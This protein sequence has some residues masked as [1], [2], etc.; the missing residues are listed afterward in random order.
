VGLFSR[1]FGYFIREAPPTPIG[2]LSAFE[3]WMDGTGTVR[4]SSIAQA[5]RIATVHACIKVLSEDIASLPCKLY[6]ATDDGREVAAGH[7]LNEFVS[8]APGARLT[9]FEL[10]EG[11]VASMLFTGKSARQI[12]RDGTGKIIDLAELD[13]TRM[14]PLDDAGSR[15]LYDLGSGDS[16]TIARN[17]LWLCDYWLGLSPLALAAHQL[18]HALGQDEHARAYFANNAVLG[19]VLEYPGKL[20]AEDREKLLREWNAAHQGSARAWRTGLLSGGL[21]FTPYT[22]SNRDAQFLEARRFTSEQIAAVYRV[23]LAKINDLTHATYNNV[24]QQSISYY[25]DTLRPNLDRIEQSM[26]RDLLTTEERAAHFYF[27]F[28]ADAILRGDY[29]TRMGGY[30]IAIQNGFMTPNEVRALEDM[31][32]H[33]DG[34]RLLVP[35]NSRPAGIAS[36]VPDGGRAPV[37]VPKA[38]ALADQEDPDAK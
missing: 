34:D 30:A 29:S 7:D 16:T 36:P 31:P 23:P 32:P 21:K 35:L 28:S 15:Y 5:V 20:V 37:A 9:P 33:P 27:A 8:W 22:V 12:V 4:A 24:E 19:G 1:L 13:V 3:A 14:K 17:E 26:A 10:F 25:R 38:P 2:D 18:D 11:V 6:R